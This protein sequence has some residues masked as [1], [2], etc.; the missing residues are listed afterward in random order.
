[1]KIPLKALKN[2]FQ[3]I[4]ENANLK[5]LTNLKALKVCVQIIETLLKEYYIDT[6]F[7]ELLKKENLMYRK[8][9]EN[10]SDYKDDDV[11]ENYMTEV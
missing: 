8:S 6:E 5:V 9:R 4:P 2:L 11:K 10:N 1:M 3:K 7:L